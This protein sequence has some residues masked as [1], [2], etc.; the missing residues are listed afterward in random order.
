MHSAIAAYEKEYLQYVLPAV[1]NSYV[2]CLDPGETVGW[3]LFSSGYVLRC[4]QLALQKQLSRGASV[5]HV[6]NSFFDDLVGLENCERNGV[7]I[8][9]T[10]VV[11]DY[12]VYAHKLQANV[13]SS[14][15]TV[16]LIGALQFLCS[17]RAIPIVYQMAAEAKFFASDEKLRR[18]GIFQEKLKHANDAIRHGIYYMLRKSGVAGGDKRG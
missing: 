14:L 12:V 2:L 10:C 11:E 1:R 7:L 13:W 17:D 18:W 6:L 8:P 15:F 4:G 5:S 16:R 9:V 3:A